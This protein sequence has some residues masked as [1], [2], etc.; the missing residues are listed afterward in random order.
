MKMT[1][2]RMEAL[3]ARMGETLD[4]RGALALLEWDQEV[5]MPAKGAEGRGR[6]L[7]TLS[8]LAHRQFTSDDVGL[9]LDACED[10]E[11]S[12]DEACMVA[13]I[14]YDYERARCLPEA[15]VHRFTEAQ[16][17]GYHGWVRAREASDF[18]A[19]QS[20]LEELVGLLK[21]KADY[22]GY[23]ESP[24]D[25][26][27]GEFERGMTKAQL[28]PLFA[29]LSEAQGALL[30]RLAEA[31]DPGRHDWLEQTWEE[32]A[33]WEMSLRLLEDMG[34][35][36]E[37]G[38]QDR[39]V[40]PFTT[41]FGLRDV[42]LT[43][44][45]DSGEPFS[46]LTG[47]L[48]EGGHGLYEQ[49][50][51]A[52]DEGTWLAEAPSLGIHESQSRLWENFVGRSRPFWEHYT[53]VMAQHFPKAL[54]GVACEAVYGAINR[55]R[56]SFIRVE[57]DECSYNLHIVLR[58]EI[59]V[60]L[61]EGAITV[62]EIPELW[63]AKMKDYLGLEVSNDA[64]GCL[65]DVHW[66]H[67]AMG[68]FPTYALGNLYAA[69]LFEKIQEDLPQLWNDIREGHFAPLLG[70]LRA[71]VHHVGRRKQAAQIVEDATGKAPDSGAFLRYLERKFLG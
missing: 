64:E 11:L 62:A 47:S 3:R 4:L 50:Y 44:R 27:L 23:E 59:E 19:F 70:W 16:S 26:L 69:Q 21:E 55:V 56:P 39:A 12:G 48:H 5:Y 35:D 17:R 58:Y 57:A 7:A 29:S 67:G 30:R 66:S 10:G 24:Y 40:H 9:L 46:C 65:Q 32:D 25:A 18:S 68:Y 28:D 14:R 33:Q 52:A 20:H 31:D 61:M 41:N 60:A 43:T 38:R 51:R 42:R 71:H 63:N 49:G 2:T 45:S 54:S 8:A 13:E 15:F 37:A 53:P 22:V 34:F 6:Q 1:A 36:F